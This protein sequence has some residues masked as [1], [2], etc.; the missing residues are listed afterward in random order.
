MTLLPKI[1]NQKLAAIAAVTALFLC[2]DHINNLRAQ[3]WLDI[4]GQKSPTASAEIRSHWSITDREI[5]DVLH[6]TRHGLVGLGGLP[7]RYLAICNRLLHLPESTGGDEFRDTVFRRA[8]KL[9]EKG[10]PDSRYEAQQV[11]GMSEP[12]DNELF[13]TRLYFIDYC[14]A[15]YI[16][17]DVRLGTSCAGFEW[18]SPFRLIAEENLIFKTRAKLIDDLTFGLL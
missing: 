4:H 8:A 10:I 7:D 1:T 13:M 17:T 16:S 2:S 3:A 6:P 9:R 14:L 18:N 15:I 5:Y 12:I 11:L